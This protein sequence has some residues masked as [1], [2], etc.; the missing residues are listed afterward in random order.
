ME[1]EELIYLK[2]GSTIVL[3]NGFVLRPVP[4]EEKNKKYLSLGFY[5]KPFTEYIGDEVRKT[6]EHYLALKRRI[7]EMHIYIDREKVDKAIKKGGFT[8]L[9]EAKSSVRIDVKTGENVLKSIKKEN[10]YL[11]EAWAIIHKNLIDIF[12]EKKLL[13]QMHVYIKYEN[14][15]KRDN[16]KMAGW[17]PAPFEIRLK[18]AEF[19]HN[20][21]IKNQIETL[22]Q[23]ITSLQEML[24]KKE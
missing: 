24:N 18:T 22:K 4:L 19:C 16:S 6:M 8:Y 17:F 2:E 5:E 14:I 23:T 1:N 15:K 11:K 10:D 13:L 3:P 20:E 12:N 21:K 7:L 9:E